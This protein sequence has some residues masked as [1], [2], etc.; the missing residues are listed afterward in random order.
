MLAETGVDNSAI[1][2]VS[3]TRSLI[4]GVVYETA[5][6]GGPRRLRDKA[7]DYSLDSVLALV[8]CVD[9]RLT[10]FQCASRTDF[11]VLMSTWCEVDDIPDRVLQ[12]LLTSPG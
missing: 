5:H 9:D 11:S 3:R 6:D 4:K 8:G 7:F 1:S 10:R 12:V 2:Q